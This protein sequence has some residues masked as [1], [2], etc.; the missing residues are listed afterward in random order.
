MIR[1]DNEAK[2]SAGVPELTEAEQ[3]LI[4]HWEHRYQRETDS[5]RPAS[6]SRNTIKAL[7]EREMADCQDLLHVGTPQV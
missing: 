2:R 3:D 5:V 7:K 1:D 4:W 6:A